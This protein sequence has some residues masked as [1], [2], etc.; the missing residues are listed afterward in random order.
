MA[1]LNPQLEPR[2]LLVLDTNVVLDWLVFRDS[3]CEA[4]GVALCNGQV[5][6]V[7]TTAMREELE[8]VLT[9]DTLNAWRPDA[10]MLWCSW[11]RWASIV[12]PL[13]GS[14]PQSPRCSDPDDQK[15]IDLGIQVGAGALLSRD[16]AVLRCA[17]RARAL[18]LEILS[19]AAWARQ[20][21]ALTQ[22]KGGPKAA[23]HA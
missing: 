6:W 20:R 13:P 2:S 12:Q 5:Q 19:P 14:P 21:E 17:R 10:V 15:F 18:G 4:L 23:P 11:D 8:H 9:R 1:S 3:G 16:R 7:A 22:K